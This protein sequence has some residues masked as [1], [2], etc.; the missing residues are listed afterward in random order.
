MF[1]G[2][3]SPRAQTPT[4][5][6]P[7]TSLQLQPRHRQG[8]IIEK[9][10]SVPR[11]HKPPLPPNS[12]CSQACTQNRLKTHHVVYTTNV[13]TNAPLLCC[14]RSQEVELWWT[15]KGE[16]GLKWK[17]LRRRSGGGRRCSGRTA[18]KLRFLKSFFSGE[19]GG[20]E[21]QGEEG[22]LGSLVMRSARKEGRRE[23]RSKEG[24]MWM[25][26]IAPFMEFIRPFCLAFFNQSLGPIS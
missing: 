10:N 3:E 26:I 15:K 4:P 1:K 21:D 7:S 17:V 8:K 5:P 13:A 18:A 24:R 23:G 20:E 12:S 14:R 6:N 2:T 16:E 19:K 22:W 25:K 9:R 11:R